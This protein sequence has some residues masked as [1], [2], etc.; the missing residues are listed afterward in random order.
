MK[1][2]EFQE[3]G[4][5]QATITFNSIPTTFTDLV[6]LFSLRTSRTGDINADVALRFNGSTSGYTLKSLVGTGSS[7]ASRTNPV[8]TTG[9]SDVLAPASSTTA[10]TFGNGLAY[11]PNYRSSNAKSVNIDVTNENNATSS[12]SQIIA[13][14]WS[15]TD[16]ITSITLTDLNGTNLVQYSSVTLYGVLAG[17]DGVTTV[18]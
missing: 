13:G 7:T 16:P 15:G 18:S 5:A 14:S 4:S 12:W 9:I 11:I 17:T 6:L 3:L 8:N 2:I 10:N 1:L